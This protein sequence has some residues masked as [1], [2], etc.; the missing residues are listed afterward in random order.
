[1]QPR[2]ARRLQDRLWVGYSHPVVRRSTAARTEPLPSSA[3]GPWIGRRLRAPPVGASEQRAP[4][5]ANGRVRVG[6][7]NR[8]AVGWSW[9]PL[10]RRQIVR[11]VELIASSS[12]SPQISVLGSVGL[13]SRRSAS[14]LREWRTDWRLS[15]TEVG[16]DGPIDGQNS[17]PTC[18]AEAHSTSDSLMAAAQA[19]TAG[20]PKLRLFGELSVS[21]GLGSRGNRRQRS[22]ECPHPRPRSPWLPAVVEDGSGRGA[23]CPDGTHTR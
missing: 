16:H 22:P 13:G 5:P 21:D 12:G 9:T 2:V 11:A 14:R 6:V 17:G 23:R 4:A 1:M 19:L 3:A 20:C 7:R 10:Q 18:H 8:A 15:L